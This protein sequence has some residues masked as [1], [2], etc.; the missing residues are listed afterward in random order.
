MKNYSL[1]LI[2]LFLVGVSSC[3]PAD[4]IDIK[5]H[6]LQ[7]SVVDD[8][9]T[10]TNIDQATGTITISPSAFKPDRV[11][12]YLTLLTFLTTP[13]TVLTAD[14]QLLY[15]G[16]GSVQRTVIDM[17]G[18]DN[19]NPVRVFARLYSQ[20]ESTKRHYKIQIK[21]AGPVRFE[22]L[23]ALR[24]TMTI[25]IGM[26]QTYLVRL[27]ISNLYD[28]QP[29]SYQ[30]FATLKES[31]TPIKLDLKPDKDSQ[32]LIGFYFDRRTTRSGLYTIE[33]RK[34]DGQRAI[35]PTRIVVID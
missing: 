8:P 34:A 5:P 18:Y 11:R 33:L 20:G 14:A 30:I 22:S 17:V 4:V 2:C 27:P 16:E 29:D 24:D 9:A 7:A 19:N 6:I 10:T 32:D 28:G 13:N 31:N 1:S 12:N 15:N 23:S 25:K 35:S 26:Y 3:R 21:T